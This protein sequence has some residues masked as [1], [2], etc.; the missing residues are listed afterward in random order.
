MGVCALLL[1]LATP[2]YP[3]MAAALIGLGLSGGLFIVPLNAFLQQKSGAGE[4][5]RLIATSNFLG[6]C[7]ILLACGALWV[8][9]SLLRLSADRIIL[10]FGLC[11][12]FGTVYI[13]RLLADFLLRF[14][15]WLLTHTLYRIRLV[16]PEH[17][18]A[19]GPALLL[20]NHM[21]FVDGLLVGASVQRFI[22]FMVY[23]GYYEH[24]YLR[25]CMRLM[26]AIPVAGGNRQAVLASLEQARQALCQGHVVC[27]FAEGAISRTGNA[28]PFKRGFERIMAGLDVPIIPVH[29]DRL[30]GSI[31]SFK[32]GPFVW[33]WPHRLPYPVTVSFGSPLPP[34]TT[35]E[36]ARQ[37]VMALGGAAVAYRRQQRD[38]LPLR[39]MATARRQWS[40]FCMADSTGQA[41]TFGRALVGSLLLARWLRQQHP[42]DA[43]V[44]LLL[45]AS[46]GGAL[47]NI[48]V[49]LAGK[50]PVNLHCTAGPE[51]MTAAL[52]QCGIQTILT[53][54]PFL[55][56]A[57]IA[58]C[59][60]MVYLEDILQQLPS[61]QKVF[62]MLQA[63]LLPSYLLQR[64]YT[65]R[66]QH[67]NTLATVVFSS[68][69]TG[70]PKGVMLSH[71][72]VLSNIEGIAQVFSLTPRDRLL[73]SLPLFH[74]F[75]FTV[76]LWLPLITGCGVVYHPNPTDAK[77][78][79]ELARTYQAT[80]L[81][82][83]PTFCGMYLRQ[84]PAETFASLR[85]AVV[86]AE[87]LRPALAQDFK[88]KYGVE[89]LE[90]Y[91]CTEMAPVVAV[92]VPD[93]VH[94]T[95]R[96]LG[97]KPGTVGQ[98]IPGVVA[99][100][101]HPETGA[102]L[103]SGT[104]GLL[105]VAGPNRMLGYLGQPEKTAEVLQDGWY[106]TGDIAAIDE[107]GFIR[108]TDR[109]SRFSKIG[110]E[111]VPH[112]TVEEAI[113]RILGEP[114]CVVT[115][116]PDIRKGEALVV[117]YTP[118]AISQDE[119]WDRLCQTDLPK[120]WLPK[121]E[122]LY[123]IEAIPTLGTGKVDLQQ[124]RRLAMASVEDRS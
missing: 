88:D 63:R 14:L 121:R 18:P 75:G 114:A 72:N 53:S 28:L 122:H 96:Q 24:P 45:P 37:A 74:S 99:R 21:S 31:F 13:L 29:L 119:L 49:L 44:G 7:G 62:A 23:R 43:M 52:T 1:A 38:L 101:V 98:P 5:G 11:T 57:K 34:S 112:G 42:Q 100:V 64:L 117:L 65:P 71:H 84:C 85:Y 97:H 120:L 76:T 92:N 67:A 87:K 116:V 107:D 118:T 50:V 2:A 94:G 17:V 104:A 95:Q 78:I 47:A 35:A 68:G 33:K 66:G 90:G 69:S 30:W 48:A 123:C 39:F 124:A 60:G 32:N 25:W 106:V 110:G 59:S 89:L 36:Q 40:R 73:G 102:P 83:T 6:T 15:L 111:M 61:W 41:L 51:A 55:H 93:V 70:T 105:L 79:G 86:G 10:T 3:Y 20:C 58:A 22:R 4:K 16:G 9:Q 26:H 81:I 12:L 56:K 46:V 115:A 54:R 113:N 103:P 77:A 19:H 80:M 91:G 27:I 108:L 109:L 82:S 8:C